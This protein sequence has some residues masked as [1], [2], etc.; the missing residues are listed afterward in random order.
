MSVLHGAP[1]R[2]PSRVPRAPILALALALPMTATLVLRAGSVADPDRG[3]IHL[4]PEQAARAGLRLDLR[5]HP[6]LPAR[7]LEVRGGALA[8]AGGRATVLAATPDGSRV[9]VADSVGQDPASLVV[10]ALDGGQLR[11][12]FDGLLAAAFAPDGSWLAVSDGLG[13]LWQVD[14]TDGGS[15]LVADGPFIGTLVVEAAGSI[16]ALAVPSVE[17]P[18][19]SRLVRIQPG[20]AAEP[21]SDEELVYDVAPLAG[22]ALAVVAHRP[23][24]TL[25]ERVVDGA[26]RTLVD[27]GPGAV[28]VAVSADLRVVAWQRDGYVFSRTGEEAAIRIGPGER[29]R[30]APDGSMLLFAAAEGERAYRPDGTLLAELDG[31]AILLDCG[32]CAS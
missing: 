29:P 10:A 9:A 6:E 12:P 8:R 20:G 31:P 26:S 28:H 7:L 18:Y 15:S 30:V 27:L 32:G 24:G 1:T 21:I 16:L 5:P 25:V 3:V 17:A 2:R 22:G 11:V 23:Q 19:R 14:A 13:R 4:A